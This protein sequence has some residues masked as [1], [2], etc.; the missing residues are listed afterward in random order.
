MVGVELAISDS[1]VRHSFV[2]Y[3]H[4]ESLDEP[5]HPGELSLLSSTGLKMSDSVGR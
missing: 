3:C 4:A 2:L 1:H 5:S